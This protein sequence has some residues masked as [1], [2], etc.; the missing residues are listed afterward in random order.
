MKLKNYFDHKVREGSFNPRE[1]QV[2]LFGKKKWV[3]LEQAPHLQVLLI[4][5]LHL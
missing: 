1:W 5:T 3:W 2:D 4:S